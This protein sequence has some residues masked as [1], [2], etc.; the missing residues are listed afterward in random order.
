MKA[1]SITFVVTPDTSAKE[2]GE[3]LFELIFNR[4]SN[5]EWFETHL[6]TLS[7]VEVDLEDML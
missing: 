2:L 1:V 7:G 3:K 6:E 4:V 5:P